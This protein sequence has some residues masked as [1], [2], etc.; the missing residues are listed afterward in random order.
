MDET[1]QKAGAGSPGTPPAGHWEHRCWYTGSGIVFL[2][3]S[4]CCRRLVL[5][6]ESSVLSW[7]SAAEAGPAMLSCG[8]HLC[9]DTG[10][11]YCTIQPADKKRLNVISTAIH[12]NSKWVP[13]TRVTSD[14]PLLYDSEARSSQVVA[15][16]DLEKRQVLTFLPRWVQSRCW[17]RATQQKDRSYRRLLKRGCWK[18]SKDMYFMGKE[19]L[20]IVI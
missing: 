11:Y 9:S 7:E 14:E 13:G 5:A 19:F 1:P 12:Y 6:A 15:K 10:K 3:I 2:G 18:G 20:L 4:G 16:T 8:N 17:P